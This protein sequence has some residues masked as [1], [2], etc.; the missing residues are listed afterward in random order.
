[1]ANPLPYKR[2]LLKMSGEVL[3]GDQEFGLDPHTVNRVAQD[4]KDVKDTGIEVCI[5][6]GAGNI[7][8]GVA[9]AS[10]GMDRTTADYMGMLG[11]AINCLALQMHWN[12]SACQ[13]VSNRRFVW[14]R[15]AS[16]IF[17]VK[18]CDIWRKAALLFSLLERETRILRP[19][20]R[21]LCVPLK[22]IVMPCLRRQRLMEFIPPTL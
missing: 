17:A 22:W 19:I 15:Y 8:R 11:I 14:M 16:L 6:V 10:A 1:M 21:R 2:V 3:M 7:F 18:P 5:V 9:G 4:I 20:R 12:N 13:H